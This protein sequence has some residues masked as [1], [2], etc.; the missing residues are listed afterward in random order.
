MVVQHDVRWHRNFDKLDRH[1]VCQ[2]LPHITA[3]SKVY[4]QYINLC[5]FTLV[6]AALVNIE[7]NT[8]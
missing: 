4:H 3:F 2:Y 5:C 1:L 8:Q 6:A 7:E